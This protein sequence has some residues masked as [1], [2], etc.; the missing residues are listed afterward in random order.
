[1]NDHDTIECPACDTINDHLESTCYACRSELRPAVIDSIKVDGTVYAV[2]GRLAPACTDDVATFRA[3]S[4]REDNFTHGTLAVAGAVAG[5]VFTTLNQIEPARRLIV[6]GAVEI[7]FDPPSLK[8][9]TEDMD[10]AA[11]RFWNACAGVVGGKL[12]FPP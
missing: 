4:M 12:P 10:E 1:M 11:K 3:F 6:P 8:V 7:S 2:D 5:Q 9:L